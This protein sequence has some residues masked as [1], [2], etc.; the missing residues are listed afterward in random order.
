MR[1]TL[2]FYILLAFYSVAF[3]SM[4]C[5]SLCYLRISECSP[6]TANI[7]PVNCVAVKNLDV[8]VEAL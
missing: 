7:N 6:L 1:Q 5:F 8:E 3:I 2:L 4:L